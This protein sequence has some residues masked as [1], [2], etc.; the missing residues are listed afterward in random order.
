MF[1]KC[2][3]WMWLHRKFSFCLLLAAVLVALNIVA[4][5]HAYSMTHFREGGSRTASPETLPFFAKAQ[6]VLLGV[7]IPR[8]CNHADPS[9][10]GLTFETLQFQGKDGVSLEAWHLAN[11]SAKG[12][13]LLLHGYA[14]CKAS[15]LSEAS[16]FHDLGYAVVLLDLR[17][18]G[19]SAGNETTIGVYEAEDVAAVVESLRKKHPDQPLILYG[20]SMG[21]VAILRAIAENG[22]QPEAVVVECPFDRLLS[23][24]ENRFSAI[25]LPAFPCAHLLVFWGG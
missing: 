3:R 8:P 20:Q 16:A 6:V 4:Y 5:N 7:N 18:S 22:V 1:R 14:A 9:S 19:G 21:S 17:G 12:L 25:G 24:V 13:V 2:L 11:S 23:T 10:Q 15:L